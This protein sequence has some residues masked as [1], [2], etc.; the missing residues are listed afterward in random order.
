L[1]GFDPEFSSDRVCTMDYQS[2]S[3]PSCELGML[4]TQS[5]DLGG[6]ISV[7]S[8]EYESAYCTEGRGNADCQCYVASGNFQFEL[9]DADVALSTCQDALSICELATSA[10]PSGPIDCEQTSQNAWADGCFGQTTCTQ[11]ADVNG[12]AVGLQG[13]VSQ[14]CNALDDQTF[15]CSC[16]SGSQ[17]EVFEVTATSAWNACSDAATI[18]PDLVDVVIGGGGGGYYPPIG[19]I[20]S[21]E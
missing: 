7:V 14:N 18:C 2:V 15:E 11:Y 13:Y 17:T 12:I 16:Q 1:N 5:A 9:P 3:G 4:C 6:G 8:N 21:S 19:V 20:S 10:E